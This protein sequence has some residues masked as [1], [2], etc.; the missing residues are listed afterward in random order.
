M[1]QGRPGLSEAVSRKLLAEAGLKV[2]VCKEEQL[3]NEY[4]VLLEVIFYF[5]RIRFREYFFL[6]VLQQI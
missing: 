3:E 1:H 4:L 6:D 5:G 2:L